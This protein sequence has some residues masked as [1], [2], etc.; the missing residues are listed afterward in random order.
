M[1]ILVYDHKLSIGPQH[2]AGS[3]TALE[4]KRLNYKSSSAK[5][6]LDYSSSVIWSWQI[7]SAHLG[8]LL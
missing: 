1:T 5:S 2:G 7:L 8:Q 6:S 3:I 4:I